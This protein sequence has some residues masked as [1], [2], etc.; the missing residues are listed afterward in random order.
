[1]TALRWQGVTLRKKDLLVLDGVSLTAAKGEVLG[2]IGPNGAGKTALLRCAAG[3]EQAQGEIEISGVSLRRLPST[4]RA[5]A[6]A[7]LPQQA[8]ALWPI[9]VE[10][11]VALGRLPHGGALSHHQHRLVVT[12]ALEAVGM[13]AAA[14]RRITSL[15]GGE[16]ALVLLA[17]ALAVEADVLLLDEPSA[18]LDP[19]HQLAIMDLFRRLA[20]Q[21]KTVCVVFHDL[22]MAARCCH[23]VAV[24]HAG[25]V[26]AE[27]APDA[28]LTDTLLERVYA[29][30]GVRHRIEDTH[31][32]VPW[33]RM[34]P[35]A[36]EA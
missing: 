4:A 10:A 35:P 13:V 28:V 1:M 25:R 14:Q 31:L 7:F 33:E 16:R 6:L 26:V 30:K 36:A 17:R 23:R 2:I 29:I 9:T 34:P 11:T 20:A 18:A 12:R 8:D 21:G 24:L 19:H 15:S 5:R 32:L 3:L 22:S 27:G